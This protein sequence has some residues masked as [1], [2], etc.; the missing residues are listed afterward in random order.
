MS[1]SELPL[2]FW[3]KQK[4][5]LEG[6]QKDFGANLE[7]TQEDAGIVGAKLGNL[8]SVLEDMEKDSDTGRRCGAVDSELVDIIEYLSPK[9]VR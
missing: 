7:T 5:I 9:R 3:D 2:G 6:L 8:K 1:G 4:I